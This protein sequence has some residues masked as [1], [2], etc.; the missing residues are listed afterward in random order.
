VY[1]YTI[2]NKV[3]NK[4]YVGQTVQEN[5]KM[6]W[7][8]HQADARNGKKTHLYDSI[9]KYGV[10]NFEWVVIDST[11]KD[12]NELNDKEKYYLNEYKQ[13]GTV[14][15]NREAGDNRLHSKESIEKMRR[16]HKER[17]AN[18]KIGGWKR[19]DGGAMKGKSH[20][21]KGKP[22]V[23]WTEDMKAEHK[24]RMK[25]INNRPEKIYSSL[26]SKG[27]I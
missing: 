6:R 3:N 23:K 2:T 27:Q 19:R 22:S 1:I 16:V 15:N 10:D 8:S 9:R 20:P 13:R 14:Y 7:Y 24:I 11:A 21:K 12:I 25:V 4:V 26:Q 18:N 5:P 17:H